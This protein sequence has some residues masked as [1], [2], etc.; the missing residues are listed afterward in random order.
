MAEYE[1]GMNRD[2]RNLG[3]LVTFIGLVSCAS[4]PPIVKSPVVQPV[5]TRVAQSKK[6]WTGVAVS[7]E[8]RIFVNYPRWSP[9]VPVSVGELLGNGV[10]P[11]PDKNWNRWREGR[12]ADNPRVE[13]V[14]VQSVVVDRDN[15]L[16]VVDP[17][18][19]NFAGVVRHGAKLVKIDLKTNKVARTYRFD[20]ETAPEKSYLN[21]VR[22][23]TSRNFAYLTDSG[24]GAIVV[25]DL[26]S[27]KSWRTLVNSPSTHSENLTLIIEG[28]EWRMPDGSIK[29]VHADGIALDQE[30]D[31]LYYQALSGAT[32][33]R[34]K[35]ESLRDPKLSDDEREK[36]VEVFAHAGPADG[37]IRY[38]TSIYVTAL[39][40]DG[41]KRVDAQGKESLLIQDPRLVWPDSFA[42]GPD[43]AIYV[44]TSQINRGPNPPEPYGLYKFQ[45]PLSTTMPK[46]DAK[47]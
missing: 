26:N 29:Q 25:V 41:I 9:D 6:Q 19:P 43:H 27:G 21:D 8:G 46:N 32:M 44:T 35:G 42:I 7:H 31:T 12:H 36:H 1:A 10:T 30:G 2:L 45:S 3:Y 40:Q 15:F 22:I 23:D 39:Q 20:S 47:Q 4:S 5:L 17:A 34:I 33:Y 24:L 28:K 37:L 38:G 16:W 18:S 14:C 11:Y 13:W